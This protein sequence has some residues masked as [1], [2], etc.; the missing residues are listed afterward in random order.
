M[1][2][3]VGRDEL[4]VDRDRLAD[5]ADASFEHVAHAEIAESFLQ[6]VAHLSPGVLGQA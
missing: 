3:S 5:L 1:R 4:G 6:L 2:A